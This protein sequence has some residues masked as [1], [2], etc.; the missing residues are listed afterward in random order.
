VS[1]EPQR[2]QKDQYWEEYQSIAQKANDQV[3]SYYA[4][5]MNTIHMESQAV[6]GHNN[7][8]SAFAKEQEKR[9]L[10]D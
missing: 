5:W 6:L 4:R 7:K 8:Q 9:R 3:K 1:V 10:S 2:F